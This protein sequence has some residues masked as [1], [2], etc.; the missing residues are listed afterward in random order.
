MSDA[1]NDVLQMKNEPAV[2]AHIE[3]MQGIIS[4]L[5]ENSA[6]C[7]EWCFGIVGAL[8]VLVYSTDN[9]CKDLNILYCI[10]GVFCIL[11]AY[12][13]GLERTQRKAYTEF[14]ERINGKESIANDIFLPYGDKN[15]DCRI[16]KLLK[17]FWGTICGMI[18]FSIIFPYGLLFIIAYIFRIP[19]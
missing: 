10:I 2:V 3:M 12:Y 6:K 1:T 19:N 4:R 13:L 7:K 15:K 9:N 18:S 11:D 8:L 17:Q 16:V 14:V 5:A